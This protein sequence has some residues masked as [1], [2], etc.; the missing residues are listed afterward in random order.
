MLSWFAGERRLINGRCLLDAL[1]M[2]PLTDDN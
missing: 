1:G 2:F